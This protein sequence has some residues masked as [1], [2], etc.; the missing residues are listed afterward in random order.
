MFSLMTIIIFQLLNYPFKT[1]LISF[2][3]FCVSFGTFRHHGNFIKKFKMAADWK[4][5]RNFHV[6][7]FRV[8]ISH[9]WSQRWYFWQSNTPAEFHFCGLITLEVNGLNRLMIFSLNNNYKFAKVGTSSIQANLKESYSQSCARFRVTGAPHIG[10]FSYESHFVYVFNELQVNLTASWTTKLDATT[11]FVSRITIKLWSTLQFLCAHLTQQK[12]DFF[13]F[14]QGS[15]QIKESRSL[16]MGQR[17]S[18]TS[19]WREASARY[20]MY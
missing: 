5:W 18:Y 14:S 20:F 16:S 12:K 17:S 1:L 4:W 7:S 8:I 11:K 10:L 3:C 13:R 19:I 2:D 9:W 15:N 6:M